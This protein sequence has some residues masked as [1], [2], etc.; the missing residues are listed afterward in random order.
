MAAALLPVVESVLAD[1]RVPYVVIGHSMGSWVAFEL[2]L[3]A[4][5]AGQMQPALAA[6][7]L[8]CDKKHPQTILHF[9]NVELELLVYM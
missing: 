9:E 3:A 8:C 7:L 1:T 6:Y 4:R 2:L 5:I